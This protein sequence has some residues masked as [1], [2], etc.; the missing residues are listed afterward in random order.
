MNNRPT[1]YSEF[2][3]DLYDLMGMNGV[4]QRDFFQKY[5]ELDRAFM[6]DEDAM[7]IYMDDFDI[8]VKPKR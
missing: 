2:I 7:T 3:N 1:P 8:I 5:V 4:K 6:V